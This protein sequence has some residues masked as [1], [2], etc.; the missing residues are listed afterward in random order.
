MKNVIIKDP[1]I[2]SGSP[3]FA[4]TRVLAQKLFDYIEGGATLDEFLA[5]FPSVTREAA[6]AAL[7]VA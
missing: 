3:C 1:E 5:D 2:M 7:K 4:G 6:L